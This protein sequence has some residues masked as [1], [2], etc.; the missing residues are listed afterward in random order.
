MN[1]HEVAAA[2]SWASKPPGRIGQVGMDHEGNYWRWMPRGLQQI[3]PEFAQSI[4]E[5]THTPQLHKSKQMPRSIQH[6]AAP[7]AH[8]VE[9]QIKELPS[10]ATTPKAPAPSPLAPVIGHAISAELPHVNVQDG[11]HH[12]SA[13]FCFAVFKDN[14]DYHVRPL[15]EWEAA[16]KLALQRHVAI[17]GGDMVGVLHTEPL[18]PLNWMVEYR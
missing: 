16:A 3:A 13:K 7:P 1:K 12:R 17:K 14:P 9:G 8:W 5:G 18:R 11:P 2:K 4:L 10:V 6:P 15:G